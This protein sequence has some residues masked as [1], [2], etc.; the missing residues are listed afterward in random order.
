MQAKSDTPKSVK[1]MNCVDEDPAFL[2]LVMFGPALQLT[3]DVFGPTFH[4]CQSN[5]IR[6]LL[7]IINWLKRKFCWKNTLYVHDLNL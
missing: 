4:L 3:Y 5:F 7:N 1:V 2:D 6:L